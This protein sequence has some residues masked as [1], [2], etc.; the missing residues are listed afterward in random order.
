MRGWGKWVGVQGRRI[1]VTH[2]QS[3]HRLFVGHVPKQWNKEELQQALEETGPGI[4]IIELLMVRKTTPNNYHGPH[5]LL[6]NS[7]LTKVRPSV[8]K[9]PTKT[10][11][12]PI[13]PPHR[14]LLEHMHISLAPPH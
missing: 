2:S 4:T 7:P 1:R 10:H 9:K 13:L 3:K 12:L 11:P 14:A 5:P 8:F 6:N